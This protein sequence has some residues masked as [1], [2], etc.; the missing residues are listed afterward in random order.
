MNTGPT[1]KFGITDNKSFLNIPYDTE[2]RMMDCHG[3]NFNL[4]PKA[5]EILLLHSPTSKRSVLEILT[6][7]KNYSRRIT[8]TRISY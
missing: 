4:Y 2:V 8:I 6:D 3:K 5:R 1:Q 7:D